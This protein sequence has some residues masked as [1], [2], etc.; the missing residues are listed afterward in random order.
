MGLCLSFS[1]SLNKIKMKV[2]I[3][4]IIFAMILATSHGCPCLYDQ[5]RCCST[6]TACCDDGELVHSKYNAHSN[7]RLQRQSNTIVRELLKPMSV[8]KR[9]KSNVIEI[10]KPMSVDKRQKSNVIEILKRPAE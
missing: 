6:F 2:T 7:R 3:P 8:D 10:L 1:L 9:Q 4:F 5:S